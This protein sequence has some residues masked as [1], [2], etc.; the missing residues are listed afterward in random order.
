MND[1]FLVAVR[2]IFTAL[3]IRN[4]EV[5]WSSPHNVTFYTKKILSYFHTKHWHFSPVLTPT[6]S[7]NP[8]L[9]VCRYIVT[10]ANNGYPMACSDIFEG[11]VRNNTSFIIFDGGAI[12][13]CLYGTSCKNFRLYCIYICSSSGW[14]IH[15][16]CYN[17][18]TKKIEK[19]SNISKLRN[20]R[21]TKTHHFCMS[22]TLRQLHLEMLI[23][24]YI[25]SDPK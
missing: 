21:I 6:I 19:R 1:I 15:I 14:K 22:H 3:T 7:N 11:R 17:R 18:A 20:S 9:F 12:N 13:G 8:V 16:S 4:A 10:P 23:S 25:N 5:S 2:S 24:I